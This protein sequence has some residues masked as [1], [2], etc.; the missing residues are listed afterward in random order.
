MEN[1]YKKTF[2]KYLLIS[3]LILNIFTFLESNFNL[4]GPIS[5]V[6]KDDSVKNSTPENRDLVRSSQIQYQNQSFINGTGQDF[7]VNE[8]SYYIISGKG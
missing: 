4:N 6:K 7:L 1:K 3:L 2:L 5:N 8:S